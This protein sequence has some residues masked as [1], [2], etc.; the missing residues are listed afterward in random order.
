VVQTDGRFFSGELPSKV[1]EVT[2]GHKSERRI[3][4]EKEKGWKGS[5]IPFSESTPIVF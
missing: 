1:L 5:Q 3:R 2:M 4:K